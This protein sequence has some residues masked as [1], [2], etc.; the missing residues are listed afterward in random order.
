[1]QNAKEE[2]NW[3]KGYGFGG[4]PE[5]SFSK[6]VTFKLLQSKNVKM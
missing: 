1:M 6:K 3:H 5:N 2:N 4:S